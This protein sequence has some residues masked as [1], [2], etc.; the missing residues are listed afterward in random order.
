MQ[1]RDFSI[2]SVLALSGAAALAQTGKP[3]PGTHYQVLQRRAPVDAPAGKLEV[4]EFF[5]YGCPHC[6]AF[7][8]I[9]EAWSKRLGADVVL[10]R[11]PRR[12]SDNEVPQQALYYALEAM[13]LVDTLH[14][15][16]F[17]AIH[18]E[19]KSLARGAEIADW[20]A[21]QGVDRAKFLDHYQSMSVQVKANRALQMQ[22]AYKVE[23]VPALG[24]AGRYLTDSPMAGGAERALMVVDSLLAD[25][26]AAA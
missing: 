6:A 3:V 1:R 22:E 7:E 24:V 16:V 2:A 14:G 19:R 21:A 17:N 10:R 5:W 12:F 25:L 4:A 8:P 15:K 13:G 26:R 20:I 23:G 18:K 11:V 9:L